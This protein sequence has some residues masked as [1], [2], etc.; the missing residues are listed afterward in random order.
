MRRS[1][2]S[3]AIARWRADARSSSSMARVGSGT[4]VGDRREGLLVRTD[5]APVGL[6]QTGQTQ[7]R[8]DGVEPGRQARRP[9]EVTKP[10]VGAEEGFLGRVLGVGAVSQHPERHG[11]DPVLVGRHQRLEGRRLASAEPVEEVRRGIEPAVIHGRSRSRAEPI[12]VPRSRQ[13]TRT[14]PLPS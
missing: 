11:E 1:S 12:L 13:E 10:P 14:H 4:A 7:A 2:D 6:A 8:R 5:P 3:S 9:T